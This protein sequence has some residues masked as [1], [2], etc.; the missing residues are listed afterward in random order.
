MLLSED[1]RAIAAWRRERSEQRT[2]ERRPDLRHPS[3]LLDGREVRLVEPSDVGELLT[4]Q[5]ACWVQEL[6]ANPGVHIHAL[7]E[8]LADVAAWAATDT[9]L[10]VRS[11]GRLIGAVRARRHGDVWDIGRLMVAP[12]LQGT[13]LGRLLLARIEDLAP[14]DVTAYE[15]FTGAG[16]D[17]NQRMYKKA[18]YRLR[19]G[20]EPGVVRLTKA[21]RTR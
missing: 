20:V 5:R 21:V 4:L 18:G 14:A 8:T 11:A 13:G 6:H 15:L 19:G 2:A 17:R 7:H 10:V 3:T 9:V 16:S 1:H 12:D